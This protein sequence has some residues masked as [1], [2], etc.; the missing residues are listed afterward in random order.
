MKKLSSICVLILAITSYVL[1]QKESTT[2]QISV[3]VFNENFGLN[4]LPS[5][6]PV[7]IGG[8]IAVDFTR[9]ENGVYRALNSFELGYF[10]HAPIFQSIYLSWKPKYE[11][12][13]NNG[14]QLHTLIGLGYLH[15]LPTQTT[16]EQEDGVYLPKKNSGKP[17]GSASFGLGLGYQITTKENKS[18]TIFCR[19]EWLVIAPF[20]INNL[21]PASLNAMLS[22][23]VTTQLN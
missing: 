17:G 5:G 12:Q 4:P 7:H 3:S 13:F 21:L 14:F 16:F 11:W 2:S 23:G 6:N 18:I 15:T 10:R 19:Q 8:A 20:N 9:K 1:A 22:I